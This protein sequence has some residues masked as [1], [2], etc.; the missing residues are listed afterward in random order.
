[1]LFLQASVALGNE[2]CNVLRKPQKE[3]FCQNLNVSIGQETFEAAVMLELSES[4]FR[5]NGTIAAKQLSLFGGNIL[6]RLLAHLLK[7]PADGDFFSPVL[8][9]CLAADRTV[10]TERAV[11]AAVNRDFSLCTIFGMRNVF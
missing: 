7:F 11:F 9:F 10:R 1:M 2:M 3:Q 6:V 5:L 8:I 4:S